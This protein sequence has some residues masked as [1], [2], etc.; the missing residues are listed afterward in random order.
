MHVDEFKR[1][2]T[3]FSESPANFDISKGDFIVQ[4][5]E[6]LISAQLERRNGSL[7]IN[8]DGDAQLAESWLVSRVARLPLLADRILSAVPK[9]ENFVTP[10][11]SVVQ[12]IERDP[13]G[14]GSMREDASAACIEQI[15]GRFPGTTSVLYL[16]SDAGEGKTTIINKLAHYV[17]SEYKAK[18]LDWLLLP[19]PMG[20]R[21]FLRFDELVVSA[22]M[23]RYRFSYWFFEGFIELVRMGVVVPAFDG[24]EEMIVEESSGEAVSAV[25]SLVSRLNSEGSVLL[26][27][28]KAFFE[29]QSFRTQARLFDAIGREDSVSFIRLSINRWSRK[30]F[31]DYGR[32]RG[33]PDP[34]GVFD[35]VSA[36]F[37]NDEH[38]LLTRAV[39]VK[40][41]FDVAVS[42]EE[43]GELLVKLGSAP[44]D[45]F[46]EFVMAIIQREVTEKWL[47]REGREGNSLL[48]VR[49]QVDLLASIAKEMW[50]SSLDVLRH[51]IVDVVADMYCEENNI[52][53]VVSRQIRERI[54]SHALLTAQSGQKPGLAFD[55]ED[56]KNFFTGVALG[57]LFINGG[58]EDIRSF[59]KV[60]SIQDE[61]ADEALV[62]FERDGGDRSDLINCL[63]SLASGELST[64]FATENI[65]KLMIRCVDGHVNNEDIVVSSLTFSPSSLIGRDLKN[66]KFKACYFSPTSFARLRLT[67]VT[68]EDCKFERIEL[69]GNEKFAALMKD[70]DI[71]CLVTDEDQAI[72]EPEAISGKLKESGMTVH[73]PVSDQV[74][75]VE[76]DVELVLSQ[77]AMRIF[78]RST[79]VNEETLRVRLGNGGVSFIDE[80]LPRLEKAGVLVPVPYRGSGKQSRFRLGVAMTDVQDAFTAASGSFD[81]FLARFSE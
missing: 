61:T 18:R 39:L 63:I 68:F 76:D 57:N 37:G 69:D 74:E 49:Q 15:A 79:Q 16:T 14:N 2:V 81:K 27:A 41:L 23:Q 60:A 28:R 48:T 80:V 70:C 72:F 34:E 55:H 47:D 67:K 51:D 42:L 33:H 12:A 25:G 73:Q 64:S 7:W 13:N 5:R 50:V 19:I 66:I 75:R 35:L 1:I 11:G 17:A 4:L 30:Q 40:R 20:G 31:V 24:F 26:A 52:S 6:E 62:I 32:L 54:K 71:L 46:H 21:A 59:L 56:F 3:C 78:L 43:V 29:Y 58:R 65:G 9:V 36:K 45:Y 77:R 8:D 22:L 10:S 53:P 44:R 38:P